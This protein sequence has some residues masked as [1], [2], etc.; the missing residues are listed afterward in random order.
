MAGVDPAKWQAL[1]KW[2]MKHTS[3]GTTPSPATP[4]SADKRRFLEQVMAEAVLDENERVRDIL[5]IVRGEHPRHVF[6]S[7]SPAAADSLSIDTNS[8]K[9]ADDR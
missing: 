6:N 4:L 2:T 9:D 3:D 8:A 7:A 1:L 5:R